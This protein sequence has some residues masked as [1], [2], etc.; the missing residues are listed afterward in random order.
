[1]CSCS[2]TARSEAGASS[3]STAGRR[4]TSFD[5][6]GS[7]SFLSAAQEDNLKA[8][9]ARRCRAR[10]VSFSSRNFAASMKTQDRSRFCI[11]WF[12]NTASRK[13][14]AEAT[15]KAFVAS[16]ANLLN[17]MASNEALLFG[18]AGHPTHGLAVR[19]GDAGCSQ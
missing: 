9:L 10:P 19:W 15:Q 1:M 4:L 16:D 3:S 11:V 6:G 5:V 12:S 18:G 14:R 13:R 17:S 8:W 2:M 7:A